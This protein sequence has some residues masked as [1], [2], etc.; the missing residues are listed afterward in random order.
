MISLM[1]CVAGCNWSASLGSS[2]LAY[3]V[4]G[5]YVLLI[6][7][8]TLPFGGGHDQVEVVDMGEGKGSGCK[9]YLCERQSQSKSCLLQGLK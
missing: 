9:V 1:I 2:S 3:Q 4:N 7:M 8:S 6:Y 5:L